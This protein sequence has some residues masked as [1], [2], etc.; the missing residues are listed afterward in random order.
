MQVLCENTIPQLFCLI[1]RSKSSVKLRNVQIYEN[2]KTTSISVERIPP[3]NLMFCFLVGTSDY[4][5][6]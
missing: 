2:A 5:L 6:L 4:Y 3:I 1:T